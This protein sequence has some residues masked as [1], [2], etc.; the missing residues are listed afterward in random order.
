MIYKIYIKIL[1]QKFVFATRKLCYAFLGMTFKNSVEVESGLKGLDI[2]KLYEKID[3]RKDE[4]GC[5]K[6]LLHKVCCNKF[7]ND[8]NLQDNEEIEMNTV[9]EEL[10]HEHE[11]NYMQHQDDQVCKFI[12]NFHV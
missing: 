9:K 12:L 11:E 8:S 7:K 2:Q 1:F 6:N 10:N 3:A 4:N 5:L